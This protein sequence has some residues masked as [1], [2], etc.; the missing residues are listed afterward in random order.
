[1]NRSVE[2][3]WQQE[4]CGT[5]KAIVG[6][7]LELTREWFEQIEE[8]RYTVEPFIHS[9]VQF[10]R[11]HG[12]RVLEIGVG[13]GTDHLQWARA[14]AE[15]Y[16]VDLTERAI[17]VT[18]TRLSLY[19]FRSHLQ[20]ID[21]ESLPFEDEWFDVVYSW[22]VIHHA[23]HPEQIVAEARRVLKPNGVFI[24]M[25]YGRHSLVALKLWVKHGLLQGRPWRTLADV[26]ACHME[27]PG[28][29]AY[30]VRE[31]HALFNRFRRVDA[32]PLLTPYDH[33]HVP[34]WVSGIVPNRFGWFICIHAG[35]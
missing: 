8:H 4:A 15:C 34:A 5:G 11:Y 26:V 19:G 1:M 12:R 9:V 2:E 33:T 10:T 27:S 24:G 17:E 16:G 7:R 3:Y 18:R 14:G 21:A 32:R 29:K 30:T 25:L 31:L 22:G 6:Q 23:Q 35:K 13:A 28:T 20:K